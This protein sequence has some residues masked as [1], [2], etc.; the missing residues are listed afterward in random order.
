[1]L[2]F[3]KKKPL[4]FEPKQ[5]VPVTVVQAPSKEAPTWQSDAEAL[6]RLDESYYNAY[7]LIHGKWGVSNKTFHNYWQKLNQ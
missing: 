6:H 7:R 2:G 1:L 3:K 4:E 5:A